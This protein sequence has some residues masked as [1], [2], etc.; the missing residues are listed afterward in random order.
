MGYL[1]FIF[2]ILTL[3]GWLIGKLLVHILFP[4]K[5]VNNSHLNNPSSSN[6][7][8]NNYITENHL[9]ITDEQL[10]KLLK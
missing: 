5:N 3:G 10:K 9:H 7:T 4:K 1:V 8:V 6:I 2:V